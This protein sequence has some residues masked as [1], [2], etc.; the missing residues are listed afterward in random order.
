MRA[1]TRLVTSSTRCCAEG[2]PSAGTA[3]APSAFTHLCVWASSA[4]FLR[5]LTFAPS[6]RGRLVVRSRSWSL[7]ISMSDT[8]ATGRGAGS[9]GGLGSLRGLLAWPIGC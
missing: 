5:A 1:L 3:L 9:V 2:R 7:T 8:A 4:A 6:V